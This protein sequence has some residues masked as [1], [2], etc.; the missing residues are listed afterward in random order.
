MGKVHTGGF[1]VFARN[2]FKKGDII[3]EYEG[4]RINQTEADEREKIY[5]D[6]QDGMYLFA[7]HDDTIIDATLSCTIARFINHGSRARH[8]RGIFARRSVK[9]RT[10]RDF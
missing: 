6:F 8:G 9:S 2:E 7:L 1:G 4:D 10:L 5:A 3:L